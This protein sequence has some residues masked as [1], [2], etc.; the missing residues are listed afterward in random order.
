MSPLNKDVDTNIKTSVAI[1][2]MDVLF[3]KGK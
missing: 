2:M 3:Y 1:T